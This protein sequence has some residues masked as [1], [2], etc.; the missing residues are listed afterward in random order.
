MDIAMCL[1]EP[2]TIEK[3]SSMNISVYCGKIQA[4]CDKL[5]KGGITIEDH[6]VAYFLLAG[7]TTNPSYSTYLRVTK[8]DKDLTARAVKSDLLLEERRIDAVAESSEQDSAM[9]T[10]RSEW[11]PKN[12]DP[13][14]QRCYKCGNWSYISYQ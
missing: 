7:L 14:D 10:R 5:F 4:L 6:V 2:G 8:V 3:T 9:T 11:K 1:R 12:K 13:Y